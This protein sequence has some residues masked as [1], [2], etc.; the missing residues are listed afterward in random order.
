MMTLP[1]HRCNIQLFHSAAR[2]DILRVVEND[3]QVFHVCWHNDSVIALA[4][5]DIYAVRTA[6]DIAEFTCDV[7]PRAM[8]WPGTSAEALE[9]LSTFREKWPQA[10]LF[11]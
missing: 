9:D 8:S 5:D 4:L 3:D 1:G 6:G 11:L 10:S 7:E 2:A